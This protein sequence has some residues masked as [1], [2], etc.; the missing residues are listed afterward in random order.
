MSFCQVS[1]V[2]VDQI[3]MQHNSLYISYLK[4]LSTPLDS[5]S[6]RN[7]VAQTITQGSIHIPYRA[8]STEWY[9]RY[10]LPLATGEWGRTHRF[11][12]SFHS[13]F[14]M[15]SSSKVYNFRQKAT[16]GKIRLR[17]SLRL[18]RKWNGGGESGETGCKELKGRG[19]RLG[20]GAVGKFWV[21]SEFWQKLPHFLIIFGGS[22]ETGFFRIQNELS[23]G[24]E[25]ICGRSSIVL[26]LVSKRNFLL[27]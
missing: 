9:M 26:F 18:R 15:I 5:A 7:H 8:T 2:F 6:A 14:V 17:T 27:K 1:N 10:G 19:E 13:F 11:R 21:R 16:F 3:A 20:E 12:F 4:K 23:H 22:Q 25:R 24:F